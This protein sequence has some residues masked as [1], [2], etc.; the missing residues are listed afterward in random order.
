MLTE[1]MIRKWTCETYAIMVRTVLFLMS[2]MHM[3]QAYDKYHKLYW[4]ILDKYNIY[5]FIFDSTSIEN[6]KL[7]QY[8]NF[9]LILPIRFFFLWGVL[10]TW[11]TQSSECILKAT[12][13]RITFTKV[14]FEIQKMLEIFIFFQSKS[15]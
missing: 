12:V 1:C 7:N 13:S 6:F 8:Q 11:T 15:I 5:L 2:W 3:P 9:Q 14:D 4:K 10:W